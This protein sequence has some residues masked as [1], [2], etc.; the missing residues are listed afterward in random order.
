MKKILLTGR[1]GLAGFPIGDQEFTV[2]RVKNQIGIAKTLRQGQGNAGV[3]P[4][5]GTVDGIAVKKTPDIGKALG[6][7]HKV[8]RTCLLCRAAYRQE[9]RKQQPGQHKK[10]FCHW[11][12]SVFLGPLYPPFE[13]M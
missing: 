2:L 6:R 11:T 9:Q 1:Q 7:N 13:E 10:S 3:I 5:Q 4:G 8:R 12:S